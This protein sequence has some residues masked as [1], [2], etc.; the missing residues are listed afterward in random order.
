MEVWAKVDWLGFD[1]DLDDGLRLV[2]RS[3]DTGEIQCRF[4]TSSRCN[5]CAP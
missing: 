2:S 3:I 4:A 1:F 5:T